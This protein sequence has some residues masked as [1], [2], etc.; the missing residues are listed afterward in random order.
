MTS[1]GV[2]LQIPRAA[3]WLGAAGLIPFAA[4]SVAIWVFPPQALT[5]VVFAL[6]AYGAVI[7]SFMGAVHWGLVISSSGC[8]ARGEATRWLVLGVIPA[9]LAWLALLISALEA[10]ILLT[11]AFA[12]VYA[13]DRMA[14]A[15]GLAPAWYGGLRLRLTALVLTC[16]LAAIAGVGARIS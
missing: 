4:G 15:A 3:I 1:P 9:L 14:I 16:L 13:L 6:V 11:A 8:E 7:L 5:W 2:S 10:L 12:G